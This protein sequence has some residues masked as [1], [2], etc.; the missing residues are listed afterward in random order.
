MEFLV[1]LIK[2]WSTRVWVI[3]EFNIAKKKNN[4]KYWFTQLALDYDAPKTYNDM[5]GGEKFTFFK[6]DFNDPSD[7]DYYKDEIIT[8]HTR[9]RTSNPV[10][11]QFH[12]IL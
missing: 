2:D 1:G 12:Y 11:I 8:R 9:T 5:E 3:S 6:F 4:L 10:Y 7:I